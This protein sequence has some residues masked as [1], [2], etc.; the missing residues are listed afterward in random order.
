VTNENFRRELGQTFDDMAG[1]PSAALRDRV[2]SSLTDAPERRGPFWIAGLAAALIAAIVVGLLVV[3]NLNRHPTSL[4]PGGVPSASPSASPSA[5]TSANPSV[6]PTASPTASPSPT[7]G[8]PA[9][10]CSSSSSIIDFATPPAVGLVDAVRAGTHP[11]YDRLTIEFKS[12]HPT[13]I[14]ASPQGNATF[15]Q[16]ASGQK[17]TLDGSAGLLVTIQHA[18]EHTDYSGPIDFKTGYSVLR[19]ARQVQD[20]EGTVQWGLGL[21]KSGC[22]RTFFLENPTRLV[23]D[24]QTP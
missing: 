14:S 3:S 24:I 15:T 6:S 4:V 18:D 17:L 13:D 23:I 9:F 22:Y 5:L 7:T 1:S 8:L 10:T 11:G 16:G 21:S 20:F 12:G 19:E 2:R